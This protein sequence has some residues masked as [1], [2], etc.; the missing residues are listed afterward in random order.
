MNPDTPQTG[1]GSGG[2]AA[3]GDGTG[4]PAEPG[5][6]VG[7]GATG[8]SEP[9]VDDRGATGAD[10]PRGTN[11]SHAGR[12][13]SGLFNQIRD[14]VKD[15]ASLQ[16]RQQKDHMTAGLGNVADVVRQTGQQL[17]DDHQ[18][19]AAQVVER[20]A[21]QL[22]RFSNHLRERDIDEL[23]SDARRL[24]RQQPAL[25]IGSSFAAGLIAA[26][27]IKASPPRREPRDGTWRGDEYGP[28]H[29]SAH[30]EGPSAR[31]SRITSGR[32]ATTEY[33]DSGGY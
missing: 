26:R 18:D 16:L 20:A 10:Q 23:V 2:S 29:G 7:H 13:M 31:D 5:A 6:S 32:S 24:A 27:F 8:T 19:A 17:R 22:Q 4:Q 25:F 1:T 33:P 28:P 3:L 30:G 11:A 15:R 9:A 21:D 14:Q 12:R